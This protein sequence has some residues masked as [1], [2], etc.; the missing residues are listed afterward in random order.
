M[1]KNS[2]ITWSETDNIHTECKKLQKRMHEPIIKVWKRNILLRILS[3]TSYEPKKIL[4]ISS[5]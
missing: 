4:A 5:N 3:D 1:T 2:N